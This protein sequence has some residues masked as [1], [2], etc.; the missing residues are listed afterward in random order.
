MRSRRWGEDMILPQEI[1]RKKRDGGTLSTAE[2]AEFIGGLTDGRISEGQA[3]AFAMAV[4]LSGMSREETIALTWAM[5]ES[6]HRLVWKGLDGPVV[7]G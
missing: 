4:F 3:A 2:I 5:T 6:G 7:D 1:I